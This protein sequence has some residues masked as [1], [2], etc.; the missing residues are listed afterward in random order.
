MD[1]RVLSEYLS[2]EPLASPSTQ[3]PDGLLCLAEF[4]KA[5]EAAWPR[6]EV[7]IILKAKTES[8]FWWELTFHSSVMERTWAKEQKR[9]IPA[10]G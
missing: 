4:L 6:G 5:E 2:E 7:S 1:S 8:H 9:K 3:Q 10:L